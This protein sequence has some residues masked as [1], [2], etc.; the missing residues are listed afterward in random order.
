MNY[1][2]VTTKTSVQTREEQGIL[3]EDITIRGW[4][5]VTAAI[6]LFSEQFMNGCTSLLTL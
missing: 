1:L 4:I 3:A 2:R 6:I 5:I